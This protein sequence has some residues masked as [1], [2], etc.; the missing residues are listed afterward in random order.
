MASEVLSTSRVA[1][2]CNSSIS[3]IKRYIN[4]GKL[5]SYKTPGGTYKIEK[6]HLLSFMEDYSIPI[7]EE[8]DM[9]RKKILIVEDDSQVRKSMAGYLKLK[10][11]NFDVTEAKDGFEAGML[12][13]QVRPDLIILDLMIPH[14][15]GFDVCKTIKS[16][17]LT[18][19]ILVL[20]LTGYGSKKNIRRAYNCGADIVLTK[21][22]ENEELL[23]KI[24][25]LVR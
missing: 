14:I 6:K 17:I 4:S 15:D 3:T 21:P 2:Y 10:E 12:I 18:K 22:V 20:V 24:E 25:V 13:S 11:N 5:K 16:N 9:V 1:K 8:I 23:K 19:N 7:P